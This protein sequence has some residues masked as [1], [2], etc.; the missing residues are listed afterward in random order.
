MRVRHERNVVRRARCA[1]CGAPPNGIGLWVCFRSNTTR[2]PRAEYGDAYSFTHITHVHY[3]LLPGGTMRREHR[4]NVQWRSALIS[5]RTTDQLII[6][7]AHTEDRA[8][9]RRQDIVQHST[10]QLSR[11][12]RLYRP[13]VRLI[14]DCGLSN[15][16][17]R[18]LIEFHTPLHPYARVFYEDHAAPRHLCERN[19]DQLISKKSV[20]R[21][22][23]D[24]R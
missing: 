23:R 15:E 8:T 7:K 24:A 10:V 4:H 16:W 9:M 1:Y 2:D 21:P 5:D 22:R 14:Y 13:S 19:S 18:R 17:A 6:E 3:L 20:R 11:S 12:R